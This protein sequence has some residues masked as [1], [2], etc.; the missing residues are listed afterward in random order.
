MKKHRL[1]LML[2]LML[3][4]VF[5]L[6]AAFP[7]LFTPYGTKEMFRPWL[8]PGGAHP[9]GTNSLGYDIFA[10]LI[11]GTR[12]TLQIGLI[13]SLLT[14]AL[15]T[16]IGVAAAGSGI[17]GKLMNSLINVFVLLPRLV[18][19]IVLAT[20][21]GSSDTVLIILIAIFSWAGTARNIRA[22]VIH[23]NLQPFVE[24]C[25]IQGYSRG[26][27]VLHHLIPNLYDV[28]ISRFLLGVNSCIMMESTLSFLGFG[29]LYHPTWGTMISLAYKRGAFL[30]QAYAYLLSPGVCIMLLSL[31]FY[32]I[33]LHFEKKQTEIRHS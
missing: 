13:S 16:V 27:I 12:Q 21:L 31:S 8:K 9:L 19:M 15:G 4:A 29:D 10:E 14:M 32:L 24:N 25:R 17:I 18:T 30:R 6:A 23:L 33:S 5:L 2:G 1:P 26:H 28:L 22:K 3:L 11:G 20:F 7:S